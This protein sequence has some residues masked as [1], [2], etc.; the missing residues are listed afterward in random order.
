MFK[1]LTYTLTAMSGVK[2]VQVLVDGRKQLALP[3]GHFEI[4]EPLTRDTFAQ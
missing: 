3:G 1:S 4:D 2:R